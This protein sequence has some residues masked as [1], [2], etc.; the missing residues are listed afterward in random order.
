MNLVLRNFQIADSGNY[1]VIVANPVGTVVSASASLGTQ[2][3]RNLFR[4]NLTARPEIATNFVGSVS[5]P[6]TSATREPGE[7]EHAGKRGASSLWFTWRAPAN[8]VATFKSDGSDFDTLLAVYTVIRGTNLFEIASNDDAGNAYTSEVSF[9]ALQGQEYEIAVDGAKGASGNVV[10]SWT[11]DTT[12]DA[13]VPQIAQGPESQSVVPG[14][15]VTLTVVVTNVVRQLDVSWFFNGKKI[16]GETK[17]TLTVSSVQPANVGVYAVNV[18]SG[19]HEV[20]GLLAVVEIGRTRKA[21]TRDKANDAA[22][23]SATAVELRP[24]GDRPLGLLDL[25]SS[26]GVAP[27]VAGIIG[28][29]LLDNFGA[30]TEVG[31][32]NH[33]G[34]VG[35]ASRW[36]K[37]RV[38]PNIHTESLMI[39]DT[40]GS[41]IDTVLAVYTGPNLLQLTA[42][43]SDNNGAPD[44]IRSLVKFRP[45]KGATYLAAVDGVNG[46]TGK[47][48]LNWRIGDEPS[49]A[50]QPRLPDFVPA[51]TNVVLSA[52]A[53]GTTNLFYQWRRNGIDLPGAT[54][55]TLAVQNVQLSDSG[56][57]EVEVSNF[58]GSVVS[59]PVAL[60]VRFVDKPQPISDG[61]FRFP[62][63]VPQ[64]RRA[65]L[66]TSTDLI[67]WT[68]LRPVIAGGTIEE[69]ASSDGQFY[70][71]VFE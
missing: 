67:N 8:G 53:T 38:D 45:V 14:E 47:I 60:I 59:E 35:G 17:P 34:I 49:I 50:T 65:W 26:G 28:S 40:I 11:L 57:Y 41:A 36:F 1:Q 16:P 48:E 58:M 22:S 21:Y 30:R 42:I 12:F 39:L 2:P 46:V 4:D 62:G 27:P 7:P 19:R 52:V 15:K 31:E 70:R 68:R 6:N 43:A 54:N 18:A 3:P 61:K 29:Q 55:A 51:G 69:L 56:T 24:E 37:L 32:R 23:E 5:G 13:E 20:K 9:N 66:E 25:R 63:F 64:G 71:I 10:L 44:G 33:G